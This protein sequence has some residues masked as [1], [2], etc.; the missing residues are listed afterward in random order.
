LR[1]K[2]AAF[3]EAVTIRGAAEKTI[4]SE[5]LFLMVVDGQWLYIKDTKPGQEEAS[6]VAVPLG[7]L[8]FVVAVEATKVFRQAQKPGNVE[9]PQDEYARGHEVVSDEMLGFRKKP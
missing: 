3:K 5:G 4:T 7:N 1:V 9:L 2:I 8:K 6:P